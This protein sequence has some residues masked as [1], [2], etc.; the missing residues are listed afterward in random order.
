VRAKNS[1]N[2]E[3]NHFQS[4]QEMNSLLAGISYHETTPEQ[5]LRQLEMSEKKVLEEVSLI[6]KSR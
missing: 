1:R 2:Q 3:E 5:H 6:F 4:S